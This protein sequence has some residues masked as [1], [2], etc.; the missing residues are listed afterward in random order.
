MYG[1]KKKLAGGVSSY[2][3]G[4]HEREPGP[5]TA[6]LDRPGCWAKCLPSLKQECKIMITRHWHSVSPG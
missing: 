5:G 6:T 1:L 4:G 2:S 3:G